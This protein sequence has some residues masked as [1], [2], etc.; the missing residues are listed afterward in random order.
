VISL[1]KEN[2]TK[3]KSIV[4]VIEDEKDLLHAIEKSLEAKGLKVLP[5]TEGIV[6]L[7][8]FSNENLREED[9]PDVIWLDYYLGDTNGLS[10]V[11]ELR[12]L[13]KYKDIPVVVVSN[14]GVQEKVNTMLALGVRKY[15]LKANHSLEN[16]IQNVLSQINK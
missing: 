13:E 14:G 2:M 10:F 5:Y 15:L 9:V 12:R 1:D 7:D 16:I 8:Y 6:A 11:Q 3:E 4:M